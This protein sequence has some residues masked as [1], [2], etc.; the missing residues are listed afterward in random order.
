MNFN[1][2]GYKQARL[3]FL[4]LIGGLWLFAFFLIMDS[5]KT[6]SDFKVI[7]GHVLEAGNTRLKMLRGGNNYN[8]VYYFRLDTHKQLLGVGT[9]KKGTAILDNSFNGVK[10]GDFVKVTFEENWV[11]KNEPINQ[12]IH[13]IERE[14][15]VL[16]SNIPVNYWNGRMKTG[17][18]S[19]ILGLGGL[20]ALLFLNRKYH[21][22]IN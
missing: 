1:P 17:L 7:S 20:I 13:E 5:F 4:L 19:F 10:I 3:L 15:N 11:T 9:N 6:R 16:Y 12:V 21:R 22:I 14:G 8:Y 18:F 2:E